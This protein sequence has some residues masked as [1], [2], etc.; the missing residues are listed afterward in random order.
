VGVGFGE[1]A[2]VPSY[3]A[4]LGKDRF[5][6]CA[7]LRILRSRSRYGLAA[8]VGVVGVAEQNRNPVGNEQRTIRLAAVAWWLTRSTGIRA[9]AIRKVPI[10]TPKFMSHQVPYGGFGLVLMVVD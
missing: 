4:P 2:R 1:Q 10:T 5:L 3:V 8:A 7:C 6:G 9:R